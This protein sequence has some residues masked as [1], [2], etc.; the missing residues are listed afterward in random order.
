[1]IAP[2][3]TLR[4]SLNGGATQT[5]GVTALQADTVQL[6]ADPAGLAG[7]TSV[8][9]EI[10]DYPPSFGPP[11]GWSTD[12][13]G[14]YYYQGTT[15]PSFACGT[16]GKFMLRLKLNNGISDVASIPAS[17]LTDEATA[18]NIVSPSGLYAWSAGETDQF[19]SSWVEHQKLN[20]QTIETVLGATGASKS[21]LPA[22]A[23]ATANVSSK[24]GTTTIDGISCGVGDR[25]FLA[26]QT[27]AAENGPWVVASGAWTRPT[28]FDNSAD[29][30]SGQTI[31]VTQ[32]ATYG[33]TQWALVSSGPFTLGTTA[34]VWSQVGGG[35]GSSAGTIQPVD[36]VLTS[37][38]SLSGLTAR[39]GVTP[40]AGTRVLATAQTTASQNGVYSAASGAWTRTAD[41][42][43]DGDLRIGQQIRVKSGT[44]GAGT[45]WELSAGTTIAGSK[46]YAKLTNAADKVNHDS[47]FDRAVWYWPTGDYATDEGLLNQ[48]AITQ[49]LRACP[50]RLGRGQFNVRPNIVDWTDLRYADIR[51][52]GASIPNSN[53]VATNGT[54]IKA[55]MS[56]GG[57]SQRAAG[58]WLV[59]M[60]GALHCEVAGIHFKGG[61]E[62]TDGTRPAAFTT[63]PDGAVE[64]LLKLGL[65]GGHPQPEGNTIHHCIF[66]G[67]SQQAFICGSSASRKLVRGSVS[68][69]GVTGN[70]PVG[71]QVIAR[72]NSAN[73][74]GDPS[75]TF[76]ASAKT[77]TRSAG[78]WINDGFYVGQ[79][80][81]TKNTVLNN[82]VSTQITALTATVMT[83]GNAVLVNE[84]PITGVTVVSYS[85][86]GH[87][88]VESYS[89]GTLV[90]AFDRVRN[91][92][93]KVFAHAD[94]RL[95]QCVS[96]IYMPLA[97]DTHIINCRGVGLYY[98]A[99]ISG[100]VNTYIR[101]AAF[102]ADG[103][104]DHPIVGGQSII[105]GEV[106]IITEPGV[107]AF[108]CGVF[109]NTARGTKIDIHSGDP[110]LRGELM[111]IESGE[112]IE[113][114]GAISHTT[115]GGGG[116]V[117]RCDGV[118]NVTV[119]PRL[120]A[121]ASD[122]LVAFLGS[123][124]YLRGN[125]TLT[126]SASA[127]T[128][129]RSAGSWITDGFAFGDTISV[130][131]SASN[132]L[133]DQVI[134]GLTATVMTLSAATL[135]NE[136]PS[137]NVGVVT[138]IKTS[139][140]QFPVVDCPQFT[141][142]GLTLGANG[143]SFTDMAW[144]W[145]DG[146]W[147][148]TG[149]LEGVKLFSIFGVQ[150]P[151]CD[152][153]CSSGT[154][155][156]LSTANVH[157]TTSTSSAHVHGVVRPSD[158]GVYSYLQALG[159]FGAEAGAGSG[160]PRCSFVHDGEFPCT[161]YHESSTESDPTRRQ[162]LPGGGNLY[163]PACPYEKLGTSAN[164][165]TIASS[166]SFTF[167]DVPSGLSIPVGATVK[168]KAT[169]GATGAIYGTVTAYSG[170]SLTFTATRSTGSGTG[171]AWELSVPAVRYIVE[172]AYYP[173]L[174]RWVVTNV[175]GPDNPEPA[176]VADSNGQTIQ[177]SGGEW[178]T[179]TSTSGTYSHTITGVGCPVG[180]CILVTRLDSAAFAITFTDSVSGETFTMPAS[181]PSWARW[182]KLA[183]GAMQIREWG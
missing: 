154:A 109:L 24:S 126:F 124:T 25:V 122:Y 66:T 30:L 17:Q 12:S 71:S 75:L 43:A 38:D 153:D 1:M 103:C 47:M 10:Y 181:A 166:G 168:L 42:D 107:N 52:V 172:Q 45:I 176:T 165:K 120:A 40:V 20:Q 41:C 110:A 23:A 180:K 34:L 90:V 121:T 117:V 27:A 7:A 70:W 178:R 93:N 132:E 133:V 31:I 182:Q 98:F 79:T 116:W 145:A 167:N 96:G 86:I 156:S 53:S 143:T 39:D 64:V 32:G 87:G 130:Y 97:S 36:I 112:G 33:G 91:E 81:R 177:W 54:T 77:V 85:A 4:V 118:K 160:S 139:A 55:V 6:S 183:S 48:A 82:I 106:N 111:E 72:P 18:I 161:F 119:R 65:T 80:I 131:N 170:T 157:V 49:R 73:M 88:V 135:V 29:L 59:N 100:S 89:A 134:T 92:D 69:S 9:F 62:G 104:F 61:D 149:N 151:F 148:H 125:P 101:G 142:A 78:S 56:V 158:S 94:W 105:G 8:R 5:G 162:R 19:A 129:T 146:T 14:V 67:A 60:D 28:D 68:F 95:H 136:G 102:D 26:F 171:T 150:V 164:S 140:S 128:I 84:G 123:R 99:D 57:V 147:H 58:S 35:A 179:I 63:A 22:K 13:N 15:P 11:A 74:I 51:G 169:A 175:I 137:A 16:W 21:L 152:V 2:Y 155:L 173:G 50:I 141:G 159:Y 108:A 138:Q 76:S 174:Q 46:T 113:I 37:N 114:G 44:L 144:R 3:A 163:L 115:I 127:K 83:L